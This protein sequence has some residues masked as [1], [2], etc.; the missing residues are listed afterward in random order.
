MAETTKGHLVA[1]HQYKIS[2][3][4]HDAK[5]EL[6][7]K[8]ECIERK[9]H[10]VVEGIVDRKLERNL[11]L[12][13]S[14]L[15]FF[16]EELD[17]LVKE[18][19][20]STFNYN[21]EFK[22]EMMYAR[23]TYMIMVIS[24]SL[25][26]E[27]IFGL[28]IFLLQLTLIIFILEEFTDSTSAVGFMNIDIP[29]R[30]N[31]VMYPLAQFI[32]ILVSCLLQGDIFSSLHL[33]TE[34][35]L[36]LHDNPTIFLESIGLPD[37]SNQ[38]KLYQKF[39]FHAIFPNI[40][41]FMQG[42]LVQIISFVLIVQSKDILDLFKDFSA[43]QLISTIDE[44]AFYLCSSGVFGITLFHKSNEVKKISFETKF[45]R[46]NSRKCCI[47]IHSL[48][49]LMVMLVMFSSWIYV[50]D[51]QNGLK[52]A[53]ERYPNCTRINKKFSDKKCD[54]DFNVKVCGYD[55]GDCIQFNSEYTRC[56]A[57]D[58]NIVGDT[59]CIL[60]GDENDMIQGICNKC[61]DPNVWTPACKWDGYDCCNVDDTA[62]LQLGDGICNPNDDLNTPL[63]GYDGGDCVALN[64]LRV[65]Y[66]KCSAQFPERVFDGKCMLGD[67]FKL[68]TYEIDQ[69]TYLPYCNNGVGCCIDNPE[70]LG[71]GQCDQVYNNKE[72]GYDL[73]DCKDRYAFS[74]NCSYDGLDCCS[75]DNTD[76]LGD[77]RCDHYP[78]NSLLCNFD[79][80][81]C[82]CF[83]NNGE[84]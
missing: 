23:D 17:A 84:I 7:D 10:S 40:L 27:W 9:L 70:L 50:L 56:S 6:L 5:T 12:V 71:N 77:G 47:P 83:K 13:D 26:L 8:L 64:Q 75:I 82:I 72:C 68:G 62:K 33:I 41:K 57:L 58:P 69:T 25:S 79:D 20:S 59:K 11:G 22:D 21:D 43:V 73:G 30:M 48:G 78:Y 16:R 81:D 1:N 67:S 37:D 55:D 14:K 46:E 51:G 49:G 60:K 38:E 15:G 18:E 36:M 31:N 3:N 76:L 54:R 34:L 32:T 42:S 24:T 80:G 45:N 52:F 53:K 39:F 2:L 63:C 44:I 19:D 66:P 4:D 29:L 65:T 35:W 28:G 74:S 61:T